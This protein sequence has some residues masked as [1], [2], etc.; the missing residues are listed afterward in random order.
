M[1]KKSCL[2]C[3]VLCFIL[4]LP[5]SFRLAGQDTIMVKKWKDDKRAVFTFSL[6]DGTVDHYDFVR[7]IFNRFGFKGTFNLIATTISN[8]TN[9]DPANARWWEFEQMAREG[10]EMASHAMTHPHLETLAEGSET[11]VGS[12]TY[13]LS[14]SKKIIESHIA[15]QQCITHAYPYCSH[16]TLVDKTTGKYYIAAR[17][18]GGSME[19]NASPT[20]TQW[21]ALNTNFPSWGST[22]KKPEDDLKVLT[23]VKNAV[24]TCITKGN[25]DIL[26]IHE[27]Y[28]FDIMIGRGSWEPTSTEWLTWL[29]GFIKQKSD[30]GDL[31]VATMADASKYAMERDHFSY[32]ITSKN[33]TVMAAVATDT[34]DDS[35][36][37]YPLTVD[38]PVPINWKYA[39]VMQ[40]NKNRPARVNMENETAYIR[41]DFLP[42]ADTLFIKRISDQP[43]IIDS[44]CVQPD[45]YTIVVSFSNELAE[46]T[47]ELEGFDL[48]V[49]N[50][51]VLSGATFTRNAGS[52]NQI[53]IAVTD[54][55]TTGQQVFLSYSDGNLLSVGGEKPENCD[56]MVVKNLSLKVIDK[57]RPEAVKSI[58]SGLESGMLIFN[59]PPAIENY[60]LENYEIYI[61]DAFITATPDTFFSMGNNDAYQ[62]IKIIAVD[63]SGN[64]SLAKTTVINRTSS[65]ENLPSVS[66]IHIFPNPVNAGQAL[67]INIHNKYMGTLL[68]IHAIDGKLVTEKPLYAPGSI[69]EIPPDWNGFYILSLQHASDVMHYSL[70]VR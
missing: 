69:L 2:H 41:T 48:R 43:F 28:P 51:P 70:M 22:R 14:E 53:V 25:W 7:H 47:N 20:K 37:N 54:S 30:N 19:N 33:D 31:W 4:L 46:I 36:F 26:G 24:N 35:V 67:Y 34:L 64:R 61:D 50:I 32:L 56:S 18:C 21:M 11:T 49:N 1:A 16:N 45:G 62:H 66:D 29:C 6:D 57:R 9:Y 63:A 60:R 59:W 8:E 15:P 68:R 23:T 3:I 65:L 13:E 42:T 5:I 44:A 38:I 52:G 58:S 10:H 39:Q 17:S 27:V 12:L 40:G 55:I